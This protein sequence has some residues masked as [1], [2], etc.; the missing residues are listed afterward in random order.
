MDIS[1]DYEI[2]DSLFENNKGALNVSSCMEDENSYEY[3]PNDY[4]VQNN[5]S[6]RFNDFLGKFPEKP[7]YDYNEEKNDLNDDIQNPDQI[8]F[9]SL[10]K[11]NKHN[12]NTNKETYLI[13]LNANKSSRKKKYYLKLK[14]IVYLSFLPK[15]Q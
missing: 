14:K 7:F 10:L 8:Y 3:Y 1:F 13:D 11:N 12:L 6:N 2:N 9:H 4:L 15:I 5:K